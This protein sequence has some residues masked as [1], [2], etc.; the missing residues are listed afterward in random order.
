M[1]LTL[2]KILTWAPFKF[3]ADLACSSAARGWVLLFCETCWNV[4]ANLDCSRPS[5]SIAVHCKIWFS[6]NTAHC[7]RLGS[8][9]EFLQPL[10]PFCRPSFHRRCICHGVRWA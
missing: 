8:E 4:V 6:V 5:A 10:L 3:L 9:S 2:C 7:L 1:L